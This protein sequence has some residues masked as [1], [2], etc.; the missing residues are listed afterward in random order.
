MPLDG[1]WSNG[2]DGPLLRGIIRRVKRCEGCKIDKP[3]DQF[4]WRDGAHTK[5]QGYC[6]DCKSA[7][8]KT[9]YEK[10]ADA[11]KESVARNNARYDAEMR[12]VLWPLKDKPC[13]DCGRRFPPYAMDF[14]HIDQNKVKAVSAL[15]NRHA[16]IE[17]VLAEVAKCEVVCAVCHR[18]RTYTR[19]GR[20]DKMPAS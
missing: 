20:M 11:H 3:E 10:H 17:I 19:L 6:K 1:S 8:N 9:W 18:I 15:A 4:Y 2:Q 16:R 14:D 13:A 5:R 12:A 7:Y